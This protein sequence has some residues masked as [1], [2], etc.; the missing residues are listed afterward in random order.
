VL[1]RPGYLGLTILLTVLLS[2]LYL[3]LTL[4]SAGMDT[5]VLTTTRATPEFE[6]THFGPAYYWASV[7]L[8]VLTAFLAAALISLTVAAY[9]ARRS[10]V[11][12]S[13]GSAA[14]LVIAATTFG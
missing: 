9:R 3:N 11:A 8:D 14:S 5:T 1:R 13:V 10:A 2:V 6:V 4:R 7:A 12:G